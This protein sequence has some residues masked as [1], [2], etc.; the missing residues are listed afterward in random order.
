LALGFNAEM[1]TYIAERDFELPAVHEPF[2]DL[3]RLD[4]QV[5]AQ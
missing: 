3:V 4:L 1:L 2:N 5:G